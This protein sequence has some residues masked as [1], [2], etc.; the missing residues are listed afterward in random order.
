MKEKDKH[1]ENTKEQHRVVRIMVGS[2]NVKMKQTFEK[3]ALKS[4]KRL[5]SYVESKMSKGDVPAWVSQ[6]A[7]PY[8]DKDSGAVVCL[9]VVPRSRL[10]GRGMK[11]GRRE[12]H[13]QKAL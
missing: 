8:L 13:P 10:W 6:E 1:Q 11:Q 5:K 7:E 2:L 4:M 3:Y 9:E 12:N